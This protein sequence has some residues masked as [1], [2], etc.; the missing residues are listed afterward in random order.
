MTPSG[1]LELVLTQRQVGIPEELQISH[2]FARGYNAKEKPVERF[3]RT[4]SEW[5]KNTFDEYC[6][7][8]PVSRPERLKRMFSQHQ[9]FE[10]GR[11]ESSPLISWEEYQAKLAQ[12]IADFNQTPHERTSLEGRRDC[13]PAGGIPQAVSNA[14]RYFS[15]NG[16]LIAD[17]DGRPS[18]AK[19]RGKLFQAR[20]VLLVR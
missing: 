10:R 19:E 16:L 1:G 3:F 18:T 4:L 14:L 11:R 17:E 12:F 2:L 8:G 9:A 13:D 5:E 15:G 7:S 6:G 20:L